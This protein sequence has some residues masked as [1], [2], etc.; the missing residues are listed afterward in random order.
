[1]TDDPETDG[2]EVVHVARRAW[3]DDE[4][5]KHGLAALRLAVLEDLIRE[6]RC[7]LTGTGDVAITLKPSGLGTVVGRA[8]AKCTDPAC[9][10]LAAAQRTARP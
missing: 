1:M 3:T 2:P 8:S 10:D 4:V 7:G 9:V 5:A 6:A